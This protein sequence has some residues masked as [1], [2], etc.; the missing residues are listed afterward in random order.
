[1]N[2]AGDA[3]E[4]REPPAA[5]RLPVR[6]RA[7]SDADLEALRQLEASAF[8]A[9][10]TAAQ[11]AEFWSV[12][13]G[14]GWLAEDA[15]G[16]AIGFALFREIPGEAEL[17]RVATHP[18]WQRRSVAR[19]L[20]AWALAEFDRAGIDCLLEVRADNLAAQKLYDS[21]DFERQGQRKRYY[22]DGCD[23]WLFARRA[24]R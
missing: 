5:G 12:P 13:G 3:R 14:R 9:P 15:A 19:R 7:A 8:D 23:A 10:W 1:M 21:L 2:R 17:L 4:R 6:F 20:L 11:I 22:R 18:A 24:R 16:R